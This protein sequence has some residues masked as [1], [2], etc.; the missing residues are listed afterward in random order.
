[1]VQL[2]IRCQPRV[3][4]SSDALDQWLEQQVS[5]LRAEAPHR[6]IRLS[7]LAQG[8]PTAIGWLVELELAEEDPLLVGDRLADALRDMQ[9][10][11]LQPTLLV[12]SSQDPPPPASS[13]FAPWTSGARA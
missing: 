13:R 11:G 8:L 2:A 10:L 12:P 1:M 9:L 5:N 3:P 7:R 6:I 4:V